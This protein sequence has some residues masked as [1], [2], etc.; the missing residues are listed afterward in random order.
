MQMT[1]RQALTLMAATVATP[2]LSA[3]RRITLRPEAVET[4]VAGHRLPMLAFNGQV[5]G[6]EIRLTQGEAA[7][8]RLE[9]GLRDGALVHWHGLRVPNRMDGV[10][11]LTQD[12]V[13]PGESFDYRFD[14][15]DA[16]TYWYHSHYLSYEQVSRGL[17]GAF[18]VE[19]RNPPEVDHDITVQLFDMLLGVQSR[20]LVD[21]VEDEPIW[22]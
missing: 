13:I 14:V 12:V 1:R 5:P 7:H 18:I 4:M 19:E 16:G 8:I 11:V 6:P 3:P 17:F 20:H 9:N 2:A 21:R 15:R 10:N 22:L